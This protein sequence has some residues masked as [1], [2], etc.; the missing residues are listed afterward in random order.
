MSS[1]APFGLCGNSPFAGL[2]SGF[3]YVKT[4]WLL[5]FKVWRISGVV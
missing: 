5:S 2:P 3:V 1:M 4:N